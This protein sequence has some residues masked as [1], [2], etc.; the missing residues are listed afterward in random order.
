[1]RERLVEIL[2]HFGFVH[3]TPRRGLVIPSPTKQSIDMLCRL[4]DEV[5]WD[6]TM[7]EI[8][9]GGKFA[10]GVEVADARK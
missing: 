1:M 10:Q 2:I 3:A 4:P 9:F 6:D 8:Y 7:Y 5:S